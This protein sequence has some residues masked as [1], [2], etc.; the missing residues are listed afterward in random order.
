MKELSEKCEHYSEEVKK[1]KKMLK[2]YIKRSKTSKTLKFKTSNHYITFIFLSFKIVNLH[3]DRFA[4]ILNSSS[5]I[6]MNGS[7][8]LDNDKANLNS[9][10]ITLTGVNGKSLNVNNSQLANGSI[11]V[12][13]IKSKNTGEFL[14]VLEWKVEEEPKIISKLIEGE[15]LADVN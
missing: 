6:S 2:V 11:Y 7:S 3:G 12:P 15:Y 10:S 9:T 8:Y 1:Y 14:G 5:T 13:Q 4:G